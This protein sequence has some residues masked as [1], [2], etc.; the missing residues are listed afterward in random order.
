MEPTNFIQADSAGMAILLVVATG[1]VGAYG[2]CH[3]RPLKQAA[4]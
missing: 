2:A 1:M 3:C 4:A